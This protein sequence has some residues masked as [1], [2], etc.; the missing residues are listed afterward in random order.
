MKWTKLVEVKGKTSMHNKPELVL[1]YHTISKQVM[2]HR[3]RTRMKEYDPEELHNRL[4]EIWKTADE[5]E[6]YAIEE[7]PRLWWFQYNMEQK[8]ELDV[9]PY[10]EYFVAQEPVLL[11]CDE[12]GR[13]HV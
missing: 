8:S 2:Q 5:A 12:I 6:M 13:A 1:E 9:Y 7:L 4:E 10:A 11:P 3:I